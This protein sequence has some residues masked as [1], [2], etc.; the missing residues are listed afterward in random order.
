[1]PGAARIATIENFLRSRE[2]CHA[3]QALATAADSVVE[4]F[5][6]CLRCER[7]L[8]EI[9]VENYARWV[10]KF[11]VWRFGCGDIC[12]SD[13]RTD[14]AA[15]FIQGEAKRMRPAA[16]KNIANALRSFFR[17]SQ[18]RGEVS[19]GLVASV[20]TVATWTSTPPIPRAISAEHA[21]RAIDS[22]DRQSAVGLR[23]RTVLLLLARLGL[24]ACEIIRLMLDDIDWDRAQLRVCGKGGCESLLPLA[25][26]VGEAIAAYLQHGRTASPDRHLFL[27]SVAPIVGL[28]EGSDGIGAIVRHALLRARVDASHRGSHQF[29]HALAV[30]MLQLGASLPEIGR[31]LRHR[32]VQSTS[33]YA[34]VDLNALRTLAMPWPGGAL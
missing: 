16:L 13:V 10:Q 18:F 29:R 30:R 9:T 27:R 11:L 12:L 20:P 31:V 17:Y 26:D 28:M 23:D 2:V 14:A 3:S 34:K 24:R 21:Q 32:S 33:I 25:A 4:E 5:A 1:M 19:A 15:A 8:A 22:C 6:L 7:G